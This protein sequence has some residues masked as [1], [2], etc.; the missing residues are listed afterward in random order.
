MRYCYPQEQQELFT[1]RQTELA[2][3]AHYLDTL[4]RGQPEHAAI[5]GPRRIGKT[6]LLKEFLRQTLGQK[7]AVAPVYM[8]FTFLCSSPEQF[9]TGY[10][11]HIC[12]WLTT[13]GKENP[14]PYLTPTELSTQLLLVGERDLYKAI[15]P[16]T[17]LLERAHVDRQALLRQT[18]RLPQVIGEQRG[19]PLLLICDEFQEIRTLERF[20]ESKNVLALFRAAL[21]SQEGVLYL[22]AGSAVTVLTQILSDPAAPLFAQFA[23]LPLGPFSREGTAQLVARLLPEATDSEIAFTIH[24]LTGGYPFYIQALCR[25][26]ATRVAALGMP[27]S[28]ETAKEAFV[29]ETLS[30]SGRIYDFCR[31]IYDLSLQQA[32]GYGSLKAILQVLAADEGLTVADV[33]RRLRVTSATA[34]DY[35]RWLR[36][37]SLVSLQAGRYYFRDPVLRY[38]V[39]YATQGIEVSAQAAGVDIA[40]MIA[41]LDGLFQRAS[42]ELGVSQEAQVR[43]ILRRFAEQEAEGRLLGL[44]QD[45]VRLPRVISVDSYR[46]SDG[47][48]ELDAVARL[49]TGESWVAEVK[50]G[51]R[52]VGR[53]E[54]ERLQAK[55]KAVQLPTCSTL[56]CVSRTGFSQ[57][58]R[59]YASEQGI[60]LTDRAGLA[61]LA[62][63][64]N[65]G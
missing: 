21:Q 52:Q 62:R 7:T 39:A 53:R 42:T 5:F 27:L 63:T 15:Q 55:V 22:L 48:V 6:L 44:P 11:G 3:L 23:K 9:A 14:E 59:D 43:E 33:A 19:I 20:A 46:S 4:L 56:W 13:Q 58:A 34:S 51:G 40:D 47:Q 17:R 2:E 41:K 64:V 60:L 61:A 35:L 1:N 32:A 38:W 57:D 16:I 65:L 54:L 49:A 37:V 8:D 26:T 10:V 12:Y 30:P 36:E 50:W 31:Y 29:V 28:P 18:F 45:V 24:H 25:R